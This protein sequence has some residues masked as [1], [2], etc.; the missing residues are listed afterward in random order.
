MAKTVKK[1]CDI[2]STAVLVVVVV[3]AV[4]LVGV[5]LF[6]LQVFNVLSG[7]M[8]PDYPVGSLIYVKEVD[9]H[10]LNAGD[11]ITYIASE[12]TVVT[13]Q[14]V[15]VVPDEK[16]PAVWRFRTK[17]T[18]NVS[19]D[20]VL[21]HEKNVIGTPI[22]K[23]PFLGYVADYIQHPPGTYI[24]IAAAAVFLMLMFLP[25]LLIEDK[26]EEKKP[27]KEK[28]KRPAKTPV[29]AELLSQPLPEQPEKPVAQPEQAEE[30]TID[31]DAL[32]AELQGSDWDG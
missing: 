32:L 9:P 20:P 13:H 28:K 30:E 18:A 21:V 19:E 6:G 12:D 17:G 11:V 1:I 15:G 10:D 27:P 3:L 14:M 29:P 5:R 2:V 16:D 26:S 23:I 22:F 25:D 31:F 7:S 24:A 8:E 4:L